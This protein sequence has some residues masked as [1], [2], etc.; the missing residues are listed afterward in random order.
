MLKGLV[1]KAAS[2]VGL[3]VYPSWDRNGRSHA[4][5]LRRLFERCDIRHVID[6]GAN[7][8]QFYTFLR[9]N[10]GF[11][12]PIAS[13][14]PD[15]ELCKV[16]LDRKAKVPDES[17]SLHQMALGSESATRQF[18]RMAL[19]VFNSF[20]TPVAGNPQNSVASTFTVQIRRIDDLLHG[21]DL[22]HTFI[23]LDTQGFD[24]EVLRG[25]P[26]TFSRVPLVQTEVSFRPN[27]EDMPDWKDSMSSFQVAGFMFADMFSLVPAT[28]GAPHEADCLLIRAE[29]G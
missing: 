19:N 28:H 9:A 5:R 10:V 15:P 12:G 27:Y 1:Q 13:V 3:D 8:G 11:A 2:H 29:L 17:W 24:L 6:V 21:F 25:G 4:Q 20:L 18:N 22:E 16:I 14:E 23:K 26:E 7:E